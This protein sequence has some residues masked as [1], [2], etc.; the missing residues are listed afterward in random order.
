SRL[1]QIRVIREIKR[2]RP[3]LQL[4]LLRHREIFE[5]RK[6]ELHKAWT[7]HRIAPDVS[8]CALVRTNPGSARLT[9]GRQRC[10]SRVKP[11]EL[12]RIACMP[13]ADDTRFAEARI[14]VAVAVLITRRERQARRPCFNAVHL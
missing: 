13:V 2:L 3:E 11:A 6:I 5:E 4:D 9:V 10:S 8:E 7:P 1:S 14:P 12:A